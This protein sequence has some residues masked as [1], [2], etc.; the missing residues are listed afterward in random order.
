MCGLRRLIA[1]EA[2]GVIIVLTCF[3]FQ[4]STESN[5]MEKQKYSSA[6]KILRFETLKVVSIEI[7]V[8]WEEEKRE[9]DY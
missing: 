3:L 7:T 4:N 2:T 9:I 8:L 1:F 6:L 5:E